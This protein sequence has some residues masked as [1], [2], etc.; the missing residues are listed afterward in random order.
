MTA[1][2]P[3][4]VGRSRE[5]LMAA[6]AELTAVVDEIDCPGAAAVLRRKAYK[7]EQ[8]ALD[9]PPALAAQEQ[10]LV[11]VISLVGLV[12]GRAALG[13]VGL[14][15]GVARMVADQEWERGLNNPVVREELLTAVRHLLA[16][17]C[18]CGQAHG[19]QGDHGQAGGGS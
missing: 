19:H 10:D 9:A 13:G 5:E 6:A 18:A 3:V 4:T 16:G 12:A 11:S 2:Q 7:L 1:A 15:M 8:A 17:R 14:P